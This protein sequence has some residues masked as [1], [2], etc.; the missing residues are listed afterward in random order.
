MISLKSSGTIRS[1]NKA[2]HQK[3]YRILYVRNLK[4]HTFV[5]IIKALETIY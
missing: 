4:I 2:R 3:I 1:Q 5:P